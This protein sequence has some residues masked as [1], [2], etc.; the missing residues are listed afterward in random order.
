MFWK[1]IVISTLPDTN[2]NPGHPCAFRWQ[3]LLK[4]FFKEKKGTF[5]ISKLPDI[6]DSAKYDAIHNDHL[7]LRMLQPLY[8]TAKQLADAVIPNEY[9]LSPIGEWPGVKV[10]RYQ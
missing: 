2:Y 7:G 6:Y 4:S 9:G 3:K 8:Q 10:E 1:Q 5:D